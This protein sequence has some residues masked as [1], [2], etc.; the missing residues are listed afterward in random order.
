MKAFEAKLRGRN[1]R[2][3]VDA[4]FWD[5]NITILQ[6]ICSRMDLKP[7]EQVK[8]FTEFTGYGRSSFYNIKKMLTETGQLIRKPYQDVVL[9]TN[10]PM[11]ENHRALIDLLVAEQDRVNAI[12][13]EQAIEN[14]IDRSPLPKNIFDP[15]WN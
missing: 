15:K 12:K 7:D 9:T 11:V 8:L 6:E 5:K 13:A 10:P 14:P 4:H 1:W 3:F 2:M